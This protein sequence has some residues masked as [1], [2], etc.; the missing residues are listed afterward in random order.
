MIRIVTSK[1]GRPSL[2]WGERPLQSLYDPQA[3]A[4]RF[5]ARSLGE[6]RPPVVI[7]L[8]AVLDHLRDA[9]ELFCPEARCLAVHLNAEPL[10]PDAPTE[11]DWYPDAARPLEDHLTDRLDESDLEAL[12]LLEWPAATAAFP[13]QAACA[14]E[15]IVSAFTRL[16]ANHVTTRAMGPL[17]IRNAVANFVHAPDSLL[18][19]LPG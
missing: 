10:R 3:E 16:R 13:E 2:V 11:G 17:W 7:I 4:R 9:V 6:S 15:A 1:S 8:G 5:V 14:R 18:C 19:C 12:R